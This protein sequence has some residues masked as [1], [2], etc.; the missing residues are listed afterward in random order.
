MSNAQADFSRLAEVVGRLGF[1]EH[2]CLIYDTQEEQFAAALLYLTTGLQR[3]EKCLY[4]ADENTGAAVLAALRKDGRR[5]RTPGRHVHSA[6][7]RH[8]AAVERTRSAQRGALARACELLHA[9]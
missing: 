9:A 2:L 7:E 8:R 4:I 5:I 6:E 3:G 1:H